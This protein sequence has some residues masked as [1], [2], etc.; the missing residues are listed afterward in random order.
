MTPK[1]LSALHLQRQGRV[2]AGALRLGQGE[3][4]RAGP[5]R[6]GRVVLGQVQLSRLKIGILGVNDST[7]IKEVEFTISKYRPDRLQ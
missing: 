6:A 5:L 3:A 1:P 2:R 7:P 4:G